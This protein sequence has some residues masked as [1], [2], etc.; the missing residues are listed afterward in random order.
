MRTTK[1]HSWI[2]RIYEPQSCTFVRGKVCELQSC[3]AGRRRHVHC[4]HA[5]LAGEDI[6]I[7]D[8]WL[9]VMSFELRPCPADRGGHVNHIHARLTGADRV[10]MKQ[11]GTQGEGQSCTPR[12]GT[13]NLSH[14]HTLLSESLVMR[15]CHEIKNYSP[16][17]VIM[18]FTPDPR[19]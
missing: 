3:S 13:N 7:S 19:G 15:S 16:L 8:T 6:S 14:T 2:G 10:K 11:R 1:T 12:T 17:T 5:W 18:K 9:Q 4:S